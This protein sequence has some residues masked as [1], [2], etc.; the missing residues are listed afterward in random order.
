MPYRRRYYGRKR[1][2]PRKNN[3]YMGKVKRYTGYAYK[4]YKM[5]MWL[6]RLV[7][8]E[9]KKLDGDIY[10]GASVTN[11]GSVTQLTA[12][13][14]GDTDLTRNGNSIK[15]LSLLMKG[16]IQMSTSAS[17][18]VVRVMVFKDTQQVADTSPSVGD[19]LDG[20]F[21]NLYLAPLNN[22]TVGRFKVI[23]DKLFR[24]NIQ[25]KSSAI[26]NVYKKLYGHVRFNGSAS[27]DIQKGGIYLLVVGDEPTNIPSITLQTRICYSDN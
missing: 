25:G 14:Q 17:N 11:T 13:A 6:K 4:A 24:L 16:E 2:Y 8:V 18:S 19:V 5:A 22:E 20:S 26:I 15:P 3:T 7:N 10:S 1:R 21:T 9:I 27:T 12:V 23:Y